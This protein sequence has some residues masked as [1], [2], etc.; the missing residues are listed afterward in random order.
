[1]R[2]F[3]EAVTATADERFNKILPINSI[4]HSFFPFLLHR[5]NSKDYLEGGSEPEYTGVSS[6]VD[7]DLTWI[8]WFCAVENHDYLV[9]V[10]E[11]YIRDDFNLTGMGGKREMERPIYL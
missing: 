9:E 1:M 2:S 6:D 4:N 5:L 3:T 8:E 11:D 7:E 10:D